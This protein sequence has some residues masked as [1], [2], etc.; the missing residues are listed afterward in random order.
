MI[1]IA[2][3]LTNR[4]FI[5]STLLAIVSLG[6]AFYFVNARVSSEAEADLR[7]SLTEAAT[8]V[9]LRRQ[10]LT[11]TFRTMARL[12]A[13]IPKLKA[14]MADA[15]AATAQPIADEYRQ[16]IAADL[17]VLTDPRGGVLGISGGDAEPMLAAGRPGEAARGDLDVPAARARPARSDQRPGRH[18]RRRSAAGLRTAERRAS[19]WTTAWPPVSRS[20]RH[21]G[22]LRVARQSARVVAPA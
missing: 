12:V 18:T 4:I 22:R 9:D 16:L 19:S 6:L 5:A 10:N 3:S 7:R 17:L 15:D 11:D 20:H 13:D 14:A 21:R 1:R 2:S 8:L